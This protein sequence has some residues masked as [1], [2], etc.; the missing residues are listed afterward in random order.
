MISYKRFYLLFIALVFFGNL[1]LGQDITISSNR[2]NGVFKVGETVTWTITCSGACDSIQYSIK[3]GGLTVAAKGQLTFADSV[4]KMTYTFGAPGA[5]L[6]EVFSGSESNQQKAVGGAI[7]DPDK[8]KLSA[9]RPDDFESFWSKKVK[10]ISKTAAKP[11]VTPGE[12]GVDNVSYWKITMN[13]FQGTH[14]Q[15]QLARPTVGEKFPALL[16]VQWAGVYPLKKEWVTERAKLGWLVLDIMAHDLPIDEPTDFYKGKTE[17]ELK[18]Y[19]AIGNDDRDASYFLRMYLSCYQAAQYLTK[20]PDWNGETLV[21]IGD[22]QGGQ[23]ALVTAALHP[24]ITAAMA[25]VPA[26]FDMMGPVAGRK[27]GWPQWY[28]NVQGKDPVRVREA[29]RYYDVANFIPMIKCPVLV[30]IGLLDEVCP[31]EGIYAGLNQLTTPKMVMLL[32][33]SGHQDRNGSQELFRTERDMVWL[34]SLGAGYGAPLR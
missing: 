27:G 24:R 13:G 1:A 2:A 18:N 31:P 12:S 19:A 15:G 9:P 16:I 25:L 10:E 28:N 23:Q 3:K 33:D 8:I 26:G 34:Q 21:V 17:G 20:R 14:I 30:G 5:V 22:S 29:S 7:A 11:K 6:L 32:P 4:A